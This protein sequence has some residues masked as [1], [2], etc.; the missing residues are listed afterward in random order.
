MGKKVH[1]ESIRRFIKETPAFRSRDI[2][3]LVGEKR[4]ALLA[5]HNL[6]KK[7][8][9]HRIT[10]GWYSILDDPTTAVFAFAP[11]YLGL[12]EALSIRDL[13]EQETN[14]VVVT[15]G[16]QKPGVRE[17]FG[18]AM[19][20]HRI[21][22]NYFFGFDY[23]RYGGFNSVPVSDLEKTLIDLVYFHESP[24]QDILKRLIKRADKKVLS[25]YLKRYPGAFRSRFKNETA[26]P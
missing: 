15:T 24:G 20:L 13:W 17:V 8:E 2:E 12:Q 19:V 11:A 7:G 21:N 6:A 1:V 26:L 22:S 3:T 10:R 5:L 25:Q 16:K 23:I 4:Y 14:V 9:I 18:N